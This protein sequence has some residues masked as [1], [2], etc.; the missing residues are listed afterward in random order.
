[1]QSQQPSRICLQAVLPASMQ[2]SSIQ[3]SVQDS[4]QDSMQ[5]S[6]KS[7][8]QAPLEASLD[9]PLETPV[10]T[11]LQT[12]PDKDLVPLPAYFPAHLPS[13]LVQ[14]LSCL[15]LAIFLFVPGMASASYEEHLAGEILSRQAVAPAAASLQPEK[16][17]VSDKPLVSEKPLVPGK[18]SRP[19]A[20]LLSQMQQGRQGLRNT[21]S[22]NLSGQA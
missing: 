7:S 9:T 21:G 22:Q 15:C 17:L 1:M 14:P 2:T 16:P 8:R 12:V 4:M 13:Y 20:S 5:A 3:D 19:L 18:D 11:S 6:M 10:E